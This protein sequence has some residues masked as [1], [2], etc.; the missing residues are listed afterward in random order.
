MGEASERWGQW[1]QLELVNKVRRVNK[2]RKILSF[3]CRSGA[4]GV[5]ISGVG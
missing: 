5:R 3:L 1:Q 4:G 2:G